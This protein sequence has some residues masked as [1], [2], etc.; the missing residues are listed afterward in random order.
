MQRDIARA[1]KPSFYQTLR[2]QHPTTVAS[3]LIA[4]ASQW[5][6]AN[7]NNPHLKTS[8]ANF[9]HILQGQHFWQGVGSG[10]A[11][12]VK[13][14]AGVHGTTLISYLPG[15]GIRFVN[16]PLSP[17]G[18]PSVGHVLAFT[19]GSSSRE[20]KVVTGDLTQAGEPNHTS[21]QLA[22]KN[23]LP[24]I[25]SGLTRQSPAKVARDKTV[26]PYLPMVWADL[27]QSNVKTVTLKVDAS[28]QGTYGL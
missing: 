23:T 8:I 15:K 28:F 20:M 24:V 7:K 6:R 14:N 12:T 21:R 4:T 10:D 16:Y 5:L 25:A 18:M 3:T 11:L 2:P 13:S 19:Q 1:T 9:E 27:Q 26:A 22:R 17:F